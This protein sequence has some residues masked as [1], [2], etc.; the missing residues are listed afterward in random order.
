MTMREEVL[1]TPLL[2]RLNQLSYAVLPPRCQVSLDEGSG[3]GRAYE[4]TASAIT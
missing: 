2:L 4:I 3:V 1:A